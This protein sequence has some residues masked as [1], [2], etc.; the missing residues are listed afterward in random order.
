AFAGQSPAADDPALCIFTS[1]S[2]GIPKGVV[3]SHSNLIAGARNLIA[4]KRIG[5]AD[6]VLCVLPMSHLNGLEAT[7]VAPLVS[8]GWV[9]YLQGAFQ[10]ERALELIDQHGCTWFSAVPTQYAFLLKPPVSRDRWS[11]QTLRFCRS[12]SAPLAVRV[13]KEFEDYYGVPIIETMG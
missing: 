3:L 8:G 5:E 11:L 7:F 13:R 4:A 9:V 2:T 1:G 12:A 10:P 6:R